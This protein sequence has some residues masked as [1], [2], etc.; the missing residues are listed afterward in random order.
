MSETLCVS[1][2]AQETPFPDMHEQSEC[3]RATKLRSGTR[4]RS[5]L[6]K[7]AQ[8]EIMGLAVVVILIS[9]IILFV[10]Q[11]VILRPADDAQQQFAQEQLAA[12][13]VN[14]FVITTTSC[15]GLDVTELI[16]DCASFREVDCDGQ[17]SCEFIKALASDITNETLK[18]W[19]KNYILTIT[20]GQNQLLQV[21]NAACPASKDSSLYPIPSKVGGDRIFVKL[22]VCNRFT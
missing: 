1:E 2:H 8:L 12:N 13:T 10:I 15:Q 7:K 6:A 9:L 22:D 17:T 14:A 3:W 19:G 5:S 20:S 16:Q 21:Q 11:F 18:S 4:H